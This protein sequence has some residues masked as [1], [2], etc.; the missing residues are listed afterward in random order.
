M[1]GGAG[2]L[3][4]FFH[5][6]LGNFAHL[7][8]T[9]WRWYLAL[10][11]SETLVWSSNFLRTKNEHWKAAFFQFDFH[12]QSVS[13]MARVR[14][15]V[16]QLHKSTGQV[17]KQRPRA[18]VKNTSA[19]IELEFNRPLCLEVYKD[20]KE[21]GRFMLRN[22]GVTVAAGMVTQVIKK[23]F[24]Y[25]VQPFWTKIGL[26]TFIVVPSRR[27]NRVCSTCARASAWYFRVRD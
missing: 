21:L 23:I 25:W 11:M 15:L 18:L 10:L 19:I 17:I 8:P 6:Y 2:R 14:K 26:F 27:S 9:L 5:S 4:F 12:Y 16:S 13:E 20:Y 3:P 22:D 7:N 24:F 1:G